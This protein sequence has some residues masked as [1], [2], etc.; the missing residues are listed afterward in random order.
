VALLPEGSAELLAVAA[1]GG[2]AIEHATVEAVAA[3]LGHEPYATLQAL[4]AALA[5]RLLLEQGEV[6]YGVAHDLIRE[7]V[8]ADL[9]ASRRRTLHRLVAEALETSLSE[10][11]RRRRAGELA[12]HYQQGGAAERALGYALRA[13]DHAE[14]LYA[15]ADAERH[16]RM[17]LELAL[18][19]ADRAHEAEAR[20]NLGQIYTYVAR[21]D[22]A[23]AVLDSALEA[24]EAI[25]DV[26]G[27]ARAATQMGLMHVMAGTTAHG[28]PRIESALSHL[29]SDA[30]P[31]PVALAYTMLASCYWL[32]ARYRE[33][34]TAAER[35]LELAHAAGEPSILAQAELY[36]ATAQLML[37]RVG[38]AGATLERILP[39]LKAGDPIQQGFALENL[40]VVYE[41]QGALTVARRCAE[42]ASAMAEYTGYIQASAWMLF[43]GA[44]HAYYLGDWTAAHVEWERA[45]AAWG[46]AVVP[47]QVRYPL[48]WLGRLLR[49]Q[50]Q[51]EAAE[52][53][54]RRAMA[55]FEGGPP[56]RHDWLIVAA[57]AEDDLLAGA[58]EFAHARVRAYLD[59][60]AE[61]DCLDA[62]P[63]AAPLAEAL[64]ALGREAE[65]EEAVGDGI[66]RARRAPHRLALVDL[67][68][69]QALVAARRARWEEGE[70]AAA[71]AVLLARALPYPYAEAKALYAHGLL[72]AARGA[73]ERARTWLEAARAILTRLGERPCAALVERA[74]AQAE[75]PATG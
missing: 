59:R 28:I 30:Y 6:A 57:L 70:A 45:I 2:R 39:G 75:R 67:L 52:D 23:V 63:L 14:A 53:Y 35:A 48:F 15:H 46:D 64:L 60:L 40:A 13:G 73:P 65:A 58:P 11:E 71:E 29:P 49:L 66:A 7:A 34:F 27:Q 10:E 33:E 5:S 74:L 72:D 24:Y 43:R 56:F 12:W 42:Q 44:L 8:L 19:R 61:P 9:G 68:R 41:A 20:L 38:E 25:G 37:G 16:Y 3:R 36:H 69:V 17:A 4:E 22:E 21:N 47:A 31:A 51:E 32:E 55:L 62:I 50:G 18:A 26:E 1:V 54:H